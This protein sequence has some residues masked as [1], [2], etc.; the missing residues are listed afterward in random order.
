MCGAELE[1]VLRAIQHV[2]AAGV[3]LEI[4][5]LVVP[6]LNDN[7][8]QLR[9]LS[10]GW[11]ERSRAGRAAAFLPLPPQYK[12]TNLPPTPVETLEQARDRAEEGMR[13]VYVGNVPGHAGNNTY[14]PACG[15][16]IIE[17]DG[18]TVTGYH[19]NGGNCA[20]CGAAIPGF[21][22]LGR[23]GALHDPDQPFGSWP[24]EVRAG[25]PTAVHNGRWTEV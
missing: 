14:C 12:L 13:F 4:V 18:F 10:A 25:E 22:G 9:A 23:E 16:P 1:P 15:R 17:R 11:H 6:T 3:H 19:L 5:N 21:G 24:V 2:C 8:D 7:L 20:Y